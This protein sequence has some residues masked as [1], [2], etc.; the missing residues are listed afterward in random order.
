MYYEKYSRK[1]M[2]NK[3]YDYNAGS[4]SEKIKNWWKEYKYNSDLKGLQSQ[5]IFHIKRAMK[6][7]EWK[8]H[9]EIQGLNYYENLDKLLKDFEEWL[10]LE[11][12]RA[13]ITTYLVDSSVLETRARVTIR[14]DVIY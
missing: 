6:R 3:Y 4:F 13:T 10:S 8:T 9:Y 11:D 7:G 14:W 12:Y 5:A 1:N 2:F